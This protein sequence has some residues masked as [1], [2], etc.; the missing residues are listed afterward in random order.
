LRRF[1][2]MHCMAMACVAPANRMRRIPLS[3]RQTFVCA[4]CG[5]V[6]IDPK[7]AK[8]RRFCSQSCARAGQRPRRVP[9]EHRF[10][11]YVQKGDGCWE[12]CG[13]RSPDDYGL[14]NSGVSASRKAHRYSWFLHNGPIPPGLAV[15]HQCDNPPC[16][17]PDHLFLGTVADNNADRQAKGRSRGGTCGPAPERRARGERIG[18]AKLTDSTVREIRERVA[19]GESHSAIARSL[20]VVH[21]TVT[22]VIRRHTWHH[23]T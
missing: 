9:A 4:H 1:C 13:A 22:N 7:F 18:T 23:V 17:N 10:W 15:C 5:T 11:K 14:F 21:T 12:W 19:A 20:G 16:V 6:F 8:V 3:Q 2:S